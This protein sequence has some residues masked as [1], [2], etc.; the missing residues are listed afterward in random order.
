MNKEEN[1][2]M[3]EEKLVELFSVTNDETPILQVP[4]AELKQNS[5]FRVCNSEG[6]NM[7]ICNAGT[8]NCGCRHATSLQGRDV[9]QSRRASRIQT[10]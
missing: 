9:G 7:S 1:K 10:R 8:N 3:E 5:S 4:L 6:M 2:E